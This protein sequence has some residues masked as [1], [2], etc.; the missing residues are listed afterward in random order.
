MKLFKTK[1]RIVS[2]SYLG[3]EVQKKFW[4][5]PFWFQVDREGRVHPVSTNTFASLEKAKQAI[6]N[7]K[8]HVLLFE[9]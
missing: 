3:F 6:Q 5:L 2:D 7:M 4:F 1:Y 8:K 9:E